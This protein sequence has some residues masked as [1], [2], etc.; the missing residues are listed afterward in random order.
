MNVDLDITD[1]A[2]YIGGTVVHH[3]RPKPTPHAYHSTS[4]ESLRDTMRPLADVDTVTLDPATAA[5]IRAKLTIDRETRLIP[6]G[7]DA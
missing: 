5:R 3:R 6:A 4:E 7:P 1:P 2:R